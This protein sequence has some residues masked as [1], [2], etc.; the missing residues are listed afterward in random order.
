MSAVFTLC[1]KPVLLTVELP[2]PGTEIVKPDW[3]VPAWW[4]DQGGRHPFGDM[5]LWG[6][7]GFTVALVRDQLAR[8]WAERLREHYEDGDHC[9]GAAMA[10]LANLDDVCVALGA[11]I[12]VRGDGQVLPNP[13]HLGEIPDAWRNILE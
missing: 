4:D 9:L 3:V 10:N 12:V 5:E 2:D 8:G 13:T 11:R 6:Y 7:I 1:E